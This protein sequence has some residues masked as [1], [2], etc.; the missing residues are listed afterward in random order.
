MEVLKEEWKQIN[1][2]N[3]SN[4]GVIIGK[5]GKPLSA[6]INSSGYVGCSVDFGEPYGKATFQH[7]AVA[8]AF[9]P[10]ENGGLEV[11]HKDGDKTN[12][13]V[14]NLEWVSHK[15][16]MVHASVNKLYDSS[17]SCCIIDEQYNILEIYP[18]V[19]DLSKKNNLSRQNVRASCIG[20]VDSVLG[21]IIRFYDDKTSSVIMTN[22]DNSIKNKKGAYKKKIKCIETNEIF[23]T[24]SEVSEKLKI[25][26]SSISATLRGFKNS[27][28]G[29]HFVWVD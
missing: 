19:S 13:K 9:I 10:N 14:N 24:Q 4:Y 27:A 28:K 17:N 3:I 18:S 21:V 7:R 26:Q 29:Y 6:K 1:G 2:Y 23:C 5:R 16:N 22:F 11:N 25:T 8:M 20:R 15:T 12:N